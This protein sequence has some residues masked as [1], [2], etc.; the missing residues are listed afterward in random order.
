V[1]EVIDNHPVFLLPRS[2][3]SGIGSLDPMV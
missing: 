3:A 1:R 2:L